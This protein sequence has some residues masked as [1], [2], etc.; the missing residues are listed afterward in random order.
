MAILLEGTVLA[1][2]RGKIGNIVIYPWKSKVCARSKPKKPHKKAV[3]SVKQQAQSNKLKVVSSFLNEITPFLQVGFKQKVKGQ[4]MSANNAAKSVN[5]KH[6]IKGEFP[7]QQINW[8]TILV[9]DGELVKP[10]NVV[11]KVANNTFNFT[12]D[13]DKTGLASPNDRTMILLY[14]Q[15]Y[16]HFFANYSGAR[17]DE[18][19]DTLCLDSSP[20]RTR[21]RT[22]EV[23]IVFKDVMSDEVSKSVYCGSFLN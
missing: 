16:Q 22:Y 5:M 18:L 20:V 3:R 6:A 12:W 9:A 17:R 21:G 13:E 19:K 11:V 4:D 7:E 8:D 14:N 15:E 1:G 23:F 2:I 10:E